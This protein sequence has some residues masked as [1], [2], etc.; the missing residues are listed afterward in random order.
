MSPLA[1][2]GL[3]HSR[4]IDAFAADVCHEQQER[5]Y[6]QVGLVRHGHDLLRQLL[7]DSS[8]RWRQGRAQC[9]PMHLCRTYITVTPLHAAG[10]LRHLCLHCFQA[11]RSPEYALS[12]A[13]LD[14]LLW[15]LHM[16]TATL[17][18]TTC[19]VAQE[20]QVVLHIHRVLGEREPH[21]GHGGQIAGLRSINITLQSV[22]LRM[23]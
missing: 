5:P 19:L 4:R 23:P 22:V 3:Q 1:L 12:C 11:G 2:V 6:R 7:E 8:G 9:Q 20:P 15:S 18:T 13:C 14:L 17:Q 10:F 21:C 16:V